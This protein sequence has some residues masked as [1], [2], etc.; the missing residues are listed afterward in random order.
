MLAYN[1]AFNNE[2]PLAN[3]AEIRALHTVRAA[4]P[5]V[6]GNLVGIFPTVIAWKLGLYFLSTAF[7]DSWVVSAYLY[8]LCQTTHECFQFKLFDVVV[9]DHFT[10]TVLLGLYLMHKVNV[11]T[12]CQVLHSRTIISVVDKKKKQQQRNCL[13]DEI[14][15][16]SGG[17]VRY[18]NGI[19]D[20]D[21]C[22]CGHEM[23]AHF[24]HNAIGENGIYDA[25]SAFSSFTIIVVT[26]I[27]VIAHP[28]SYAAFN[29]VIA[30][31]LFLT[32]IYIALIW[33]GEPPN[34]YARISWAELLIGTVF[35]IMG[36]AA[37]VI[38]SYAEY[39]LLHSLWHVFIYLYLGFD[40][41]GSMKS[42][43]GW[44]PL[45]KKCC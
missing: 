40:M 9:L 35:A 19:L 5:L 44:R 37:Y 2:D 28:F 33:E 3:M 45:I 43:N 30:T 27:A 15:L 22:E 39:E 1:D 24:G 13:P 26:V 14:N 25:W 8:H 4:L 36:L 32:Y 20:V 23:E 41:I 42:V 6:L 29:I 10:A 7:L 34:F 17:P 21:R 16:V 11:R 12:V 31:W 18:E 38:D